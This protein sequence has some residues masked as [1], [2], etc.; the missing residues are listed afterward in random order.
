MVQCTL[1]REVRAAE[2]ERETNGFVWIGA[3][4]AGGGRTD[5]V[6]VH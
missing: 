5:S 3:L 4:T 6:R 1:V 2:R